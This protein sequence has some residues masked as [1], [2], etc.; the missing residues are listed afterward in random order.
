MSSGFGD[1]Y[2]G[3]RGLSASA[4]PAMIRYPGTEKSEAEMGFE[5]VLWYP[6]EVPL[7]SIQRTR[8]KLVV[9]GTQLHR[10]VLKG[11]QNAKA[12]G[13]QVEIVIGSTGGW[14]SSTKQNWIPCTNRCELLRYDMKI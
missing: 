12:R 2:A 4:S 11:T 7:M 14:V 5:E 1:I 9:V 3:H 13:Y 6:D 10:C 8:K